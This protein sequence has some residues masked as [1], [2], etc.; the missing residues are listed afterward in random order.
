[1]T[2]RSAPNV[3]EVLRSL[4][5][6]ALS[7]VASTDDRGHAQVAAVSWIRGAPPEHLDLLVGWRSRLVKNIQKRPAV[8]V[9]VFLDSVLTL[10][11][12][13]VV[14]EPLAQGLP[15]PLALVRVK[16]HSVFDSMFTGGQLIDSPHYVKDY[17][18]KLRHLDAQVAE[19]LDQH[20]LV[21][22]AGDGR[23]D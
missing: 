6:E 7:L 11:G 17:P 12:D 3:A 1:M 5:N 20:R 14:E 21:A 8:T 18:P 23:R 10:Y 15:I 16:I 13:A 2:R 4:S 22:T 19:Y 9:V